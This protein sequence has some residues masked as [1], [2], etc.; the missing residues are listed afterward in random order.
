[1]VDD[2]RDAAV[3]HGTEFL[4]GEVTTL[5]LPALEVRFHPRAGRR[6]FL[7]IERDS[8]EKWVASLGAF[9]RFAGTRGFGE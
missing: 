1:S 6:F 2:S 4:T 8:S 9:V 5:D 7:R 3:P